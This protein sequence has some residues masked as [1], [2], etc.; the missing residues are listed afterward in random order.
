MQSTKG[1]GRTAPKT[2]EIVDG[3]FAPNSECVPTGANHVNIY[4]YRHLFCIMNTL[5]MTLVKSDQNI[6]LK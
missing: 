4:L 2:G 3:V 5:S 6:Y 1:V